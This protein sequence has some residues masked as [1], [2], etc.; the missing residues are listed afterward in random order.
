MTASG[1]RADDT[2]NYVRVTGSL[3]SGFQP[4]APNGLYGS[5]T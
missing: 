1:I 2:L 3:H 5:G 4:E